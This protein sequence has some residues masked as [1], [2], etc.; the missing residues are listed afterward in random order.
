MPM[1]TKLVKAVTYHEELSL[2]KLP[3]PSI[4]CFC[5]LI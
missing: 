1:P 3:D 2:L 4:T 5:E